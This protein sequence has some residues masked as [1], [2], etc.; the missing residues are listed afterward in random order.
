MFAGTAMEQAPE[1][2]SKKRNRSSSAY[3]PFV[4]ILTRSKSQVYLHCNRSGRA[5]SDSFRHIKHHD[6]LRSRPIGFLSKT[7]IKSHNRMSRRKSESMLTHNSADKDDWSGM[8]IKDLRTRRVFS[9]ASVANDCGLCIDV[10]EK[11]ASEKGSGGFEEAGFFSDSKN[12]EVMK[13]DS[14]IDTQDVDGDYFDSAK[15]G[16]G[17]DSM[18]SN[19]GYS[20]K[21]QNSANLPVTEGNARSAEDG[22]ISSE[23]GGL[24]EECLQATPPDA[25][26]LD[27][28][29]VSWKLSTENLQ[30]RVDL[31]DNM[32]MKIVNNSERKS[33][34]TPRSRVK[35]FR[36][37]GSLSYRRLLPYLMDM[38]QDNSLSIGAPRN[39]KSIDKFKIESPSMEFQA[40]DSL[41][42]SVPN[43]ED[44]LSDGTDSNLTSSERIPDSA[45][46]IGSQK[47]S[48]TRVYSPTSLIHEC[49]SKPPA[50]EVNEKTNIGV[51]WKNGNI[52]SSNHDCSSRVDNSPINGSSNDTKPTDRGDNR[53]I[54][55]KSPCNSQDSKETRCDLSL[56]A[57]KHQL[58]EGDEI[59]Q[60]CYNMK[61]TESVE[62]KEF[63]VRHPYETID[64]NHTSS[65][66]SN[67]E[68][69]SCIAKKEGN[70]NDVL[71]KINDPNEESI[72]NTP[73]DAD[74]F[75]KSLAYQNVENRIKF[76]S[77]RTGQVLRKPLNGVAQKNSCYSSDKRMGSNSKS[78]LGLNPCS[79]LKLF[80]TRSSLGYRRLL[81][82][83]M[84]VTKDNSGDSG[85]GHCPK[86]EKN[87]EE[88]P[89]SQLPMSVDE[90][91][92]KKLNDRDYGM[93][94]DTDPCNMKIADHSSETPVPT[95]SQEQELQVVEM[96]SDLKDGQSDAVPAI[97]SLVHGSSSV[98]MSL[99]SSIVSPRSFSGDYL[100]LV[101][102]E[103][104]ADNEEGCRTSVVKLNNSAK[105]V[106]TGSLSQNSSMLEVFCNPLG[107]PAQDSR[108]EFLKKSKGCRG[109]CT[110]LNCASFRLHAERAFEFSK[111]QM[112]DAEEVVLDLIKEL[113]HLRNMLEKAA[114]G[115]ND[116]HFIC[117]NQ[118]KK[119]CREASEAEELAKS[120]LSQMNY[121]VNVHSRITCEQRPRVRFSNNVEER[122]ISQ[123]NSDRVKNYESTA[124]DEVV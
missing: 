50:N 25:E 104:S 60:H 29:N 10:E 64:R 68:G 11:K 103:L 28:E 124:A 52:E 56:K 48:C 20:S 86:L 67:A 83:L 26:I 44:G 16:E 115:F 31:Q 8:I 91:P 66:A 40:G 35:V 55:S 113:S 69:H 78:K 37:P 77:Q 43:F 76:V 87:L 63:D 53:G 70:D 6:N 36:A 82:Y 122:I 96:I 38:V 101:S 24:D 80:K 81:P 89:L 19:V 111:N 5:R 14:F 79:R 106:D 32:D 105:Q 12:L 7:Q 108:K 112:Q 49:C 9:L 92:V 18:K 109:P 88:N 42:Q 118:V 98:T 85:N 72:Q 102:H 116:N 57:E 97:G 117:I 62:I 120:R 65:N 17:K 54:M 123:V 23:V 99:C 41:S 39:G 15:E 1:L 58:L 121:D 107:I 100:N 90:T 47:D 110:C 2:I 114:F 61:Q 73:P 13:S 74:I 94:C 45:M 93:E 84:D 95:V 3:H 21:E 51:S 4:G 59:E 46:L 119:A 75:A 27:R 34:L 33:V 22:E 71:D 30:K